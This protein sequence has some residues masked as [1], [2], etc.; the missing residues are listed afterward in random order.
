MQGNRKVVDLGILGL[1]FFIVACSSTAPYRV[2]ERHIE[3]GKEL[4]RME[5]SMGT[6]Y[7]GVTPFSISLG[8]MWILLLAFPQLALWLR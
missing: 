1:A 3:S 5:A 8:L 6:I 4:L 2:Y 7:K